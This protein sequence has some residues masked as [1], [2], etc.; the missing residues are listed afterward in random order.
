[1]L[2]MILLAQKVVGMF[3]FEKSYRKNNEV[4]IQIFSFVSCPKKDFFRKLTFHVSDKQSNRKT[5]FH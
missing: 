4:Y 1:M 2:I 5:L 3:F